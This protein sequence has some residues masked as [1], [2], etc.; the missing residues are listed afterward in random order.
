MKKIIFLFIVLTFSNTTSAG[1]FGDFFETLFGNTFDDNSTGEAFNG[2]ITPDE[3]MNV[4]CK[5]EYTQLDLATGLEKNIKYTADQE[6]MYTARGS[7]T[8]YLATQDLTDKVNNWLDENPNNIIANMTGINCKEKN[9]IIPVFN[10]AR[11]GASWGEYK[12][13]EDKYNIEFMNLLDYPN[14]WGYNVNIKRLI[15]DYDEGCRTFY[16]DYSDG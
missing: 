15:K 6:T 5:V 9:A 14:R 10:V 8:M 13:C 1:F 12:S 16:G 4:R 7:N 2:Y 3:P 11:V